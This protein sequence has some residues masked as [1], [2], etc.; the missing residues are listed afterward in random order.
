MLENCSLCTLY[1]ITYFV[2]DQRDFIGI[3]PIALS[4]QIVQ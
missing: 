1:E 3:M 4:L 2:R